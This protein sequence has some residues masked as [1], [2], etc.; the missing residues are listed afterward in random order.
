M[1]SN[2]FSIDRANRPWVDPYRYVP[3]DPVDSVRIEMGM[4][5]TLTV[6]DAKKRL[7]VPLV[8]LANGVVYYAAIS[9][10]ER[11]VNTVQFRI[12]LGEH[13]EVFARI[14]PIETP[15]GVR[16]AYPH[17]AFR[18][19]QLDEVDIE[20]LFWGVLRKDWRVVHDG[21]S[22]LNPQ[23]G[24]VGIGPALTYDHRPDAW[25]LAIDPTM[26]TAY[27]RDFSARI[28]LTLR[29]MCAPRGGGLIRCMV[30]NLNNQ[31]HSVAV[32]RT[33][34][35]G[36]MIINMVD[37]RVDIYPVY[38]VKQR[39]VLFSPN[40]QQ[41]FPGG[42]EFRSVPLTDAEKH[43][44]IQEPV[45]RHYATKTGGYLMEHYRI[46]RLTALAMGLH[47]RLSSACRGVG[48]GSLD[49]EVLVLIA[50]MTP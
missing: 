23:H 8:P 49:R 6:A 26:L 35:G 19:V 22:L 38:I 47:P 15:A 46:P 31:S 45:H 3:Y 33:G 13:G 39:R 25:T 10:V 43:D 30:F 29:E 18:S 2:L 40:M 9:R 32:V 20:C 41:L 28:E 24:V 42:V 48:I 7:L 1:Q 14:R 37:I 50:S 27:G 34:E 11:V 16:A 21:V 36:A 44:L 17:I 12:E 4:Q 5:M